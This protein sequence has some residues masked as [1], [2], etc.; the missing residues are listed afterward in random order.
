MKKSIIFSLLAAL[1][2]GCEFVEIY[3]TNVFGLSGDGAYKGIPREDYTLLPIPTTATDGAGITL[4]AQANHRPVP[5]WQWQEFETWSPEKRKLEYGKYF[6]Q[7]YYFVE[8][9]P[10]SPCRFRTTRIDHRESAQEFEYRLWQS[11]VEIYHRFLEGKE[12][13]FRFHEGM[14]GLVVEFPIADCGNLL[15]L[16]QGERAVL[17]VTVRDTAGAVLDEIPVEFDLRLREAFVDYWLF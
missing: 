14:R 8:V 3:E 9:S 1:L 12:A 5:S 7:V 16:K 11:D 4:I 15:G 17:T 6:D 13:A 10:E 2:G